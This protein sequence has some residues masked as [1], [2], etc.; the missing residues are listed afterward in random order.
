[1][2][3][4]H[5]TKFAFDYL[6]GRLLRRATGAALFILLSLIAIYHFTIAG[7]LALETEYGPLY[8][9]LIVATVYTAG[10]LIV[11]IILWTMRPK[12]AIE[13]QVPSAPTS[14][15]SAQIALLIEAILQG[16]TLGKK[17]DRRSR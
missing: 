4:N 6:V 1:M 7:T 14:P 3:L 10:A 9:R 16:F 12:P 5:L 2:R 11:L 8:A 13:D 15:R 17:S